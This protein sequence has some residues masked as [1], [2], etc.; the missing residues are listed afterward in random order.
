LAATNVHSRSLQHRF[1]FPLMFSLPRVLQIENRVSFVKVQGLN[2][3]DSS[4]MKALLVRGHK[5]QS[6]GAFASM[7]ARSCCATSS[8]RPR[9]GLVLQPKWSA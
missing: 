8:R 9:C 6:S 2:Q 7:K 5:Q 4:R 3:E 1:L